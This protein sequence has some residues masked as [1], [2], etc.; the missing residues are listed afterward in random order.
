VKRWRLD[1]M[2]L[3][4]EKNDDISTIFNQYKETAGENAPLNI[5]DEASC[6]TALVDFAVTD[7][8][9]DSTTK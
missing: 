8:K 4:D 6:K 3:T 2:N 9:N 1:R 5:V 7:P